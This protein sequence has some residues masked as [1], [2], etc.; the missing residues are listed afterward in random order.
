M[1]VFEILPDF[2]IAKRLYYP[3]IEE[4][5]SSNLLDLINIKIGIKFNSINA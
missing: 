5:K 2:K 1:K 4:I 3:T